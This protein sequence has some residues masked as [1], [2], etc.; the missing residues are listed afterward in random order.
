M[1]VKY[2]GKMQLWKNEKGMDSEIIE[3]S[4]AQLCG[5]EVSFR[6]EKCL[7]IRM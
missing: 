2:G 1:E 5:Y 7:F 4:T 6:H 3:T